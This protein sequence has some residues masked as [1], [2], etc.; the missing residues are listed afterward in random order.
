M[1]CACPPKAGPPV[2]KARREHLVGEA[3]GD[4]KVAATGS[5]AG[6]V[7]TTCRVAHPY[8]KLRDSSR[9]LDHR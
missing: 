5:V 8:P 2:A 3:R 1:A 6:F 9:R 4:L 7:V